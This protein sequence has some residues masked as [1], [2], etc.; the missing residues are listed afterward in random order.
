MQSYEYDVKPK[1]S[2]GKR[3]T[4]FG[5]FLLVLV[6]GAVVVSIVALVRQ[7]N[8]EYDN[9]SLGPP[10]PEP[11][12]VTTTDNT[13]DS[14]SDSV[15]ECAVNGA[16]KSPVTQNICDNTDGRVSHDS[17]YLSQHRR[18]SHDSEYLSQHRRVSHDSEYLSQH[19]RVSHDLM[20]VT[21]QTGKS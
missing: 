14:R 10:T 20:Y 18:E 17:E 3:Y 6:I 9:S 16:V 19:R 13:V 11:Q 15:V 2:Y 7:E 21:T 8:S 4:Y 1:R 12:P 5:C